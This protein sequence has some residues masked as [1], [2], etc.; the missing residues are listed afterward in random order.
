[1]GKALGPDGK[2]VLLR[3]KVVL[4]F[5][6]PCHP[7]TL[8]ELP[9]KKRSAD[10]N[11]HLKRKQERQAANAESSAEEV[12]AAMPPEREQ[13][14]NTQRI[15]LKK[16]EQAPLAPAP[17]LEPVK[18]TMPGSM[19]DL[20]DLDAG[21]GE[22]APSPA[23]VRTFGSGEV[24]FKP[25]EDFVAADTALEEAWATDED[26]KPKAN[27]P[28]LWIGL[29]AALLCGVLAVV[30]LKARS[31]ESTEPVVVTKEQTLFREAIF[32]KEERA[33]VEA[34]YAQLLE[35][36][37]A[38]LKAETVEE[39]ARFVRQPERVKPLMEG[40]YADREMKS[41]DASELL[42]FEPTTLEQRA[43]WI[44]SMEDPTDERGM[45]PVLIEQTED[46][47]LLIDWETFVGYSADDWNELLEERPE[48]VFQ[49][50]VR[51]SQANLYTYEFKDRSEWLS[52]YMAGPNDGREVYAYIKRQSEDGQL[53][54]N[55][56]Q[57]TRGALAVVAD[58]SFPQNLKARDVVVVE[59]IASFQWV[60][61]NPPSDD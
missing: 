11:R 20:D 9:G 21:G 5:P 34:I 27:L 2:D 16:S 19:D 36:V 6:N 41:V 10:L 24:E 55:R 39:K 53:L 33:E 29:C 3:R 30:I 44:A 7:Q 38:F 4:V 37:R 50:R 42:V 8:S 1:M 18:P 17:K 47:E 51:V 35:R 40:Y 25:Q 12:P 61:V 14:R 57:R 56:L 60:F 59:D 43:F 26:A 15:R 22:P 31:E 48:G 52:L 32:D 54:L 23:A 58:V 13:M 45:V 28:I 49:S 46:N